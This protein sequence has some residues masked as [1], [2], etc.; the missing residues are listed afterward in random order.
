MLPLFVWV[1][2]FLKPSSIIIVIVI[3]DS[4]ANRIVGYFWQMHKISIS[5]MGRMANTKQFMAAHDSCGCLLSN[6][7][8][9]H[10]CGQDRV[11]MMM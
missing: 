9:Q 11:N 5:R 8:T 2:F 3:I 4:H 6:G 10:D 1:F 7:A